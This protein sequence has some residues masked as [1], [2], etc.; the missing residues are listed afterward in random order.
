MAIKALCLN[1]LKQ[2]EEAIALI[3]EAIRKDISSFTAWHSYGLISQSERQ[4]LK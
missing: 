2:K 4:V 3:K 1:N